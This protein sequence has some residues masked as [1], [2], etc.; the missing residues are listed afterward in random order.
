MVMQQGD[1]RFSWGKS[2][3]LPQ[4]E[5]LAVE[6]KF[7]KLKIGIPRDNEQYETR[8]PLTPEAVEILVNEGHD[9]YIETC[10]GK[11]AHY[12]DKDYSERGGFVVQ[13]RSAIFQCDIVLKVAP[14]TPEE[15]EGLRGQQTIISSL[16]LNTQTL[17]Y[18]QKLMEKKQRP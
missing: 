9:V 10:A 4:E 6:S 17:A 11:A 13:D 8:V 3:L 18:F 14:L 12:L 16:I 5:K 2:G 1:I 7:K 15:I